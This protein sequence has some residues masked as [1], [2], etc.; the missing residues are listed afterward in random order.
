MTRTAIPTRGFLGYLLLTA[1]I[2]GGLVMVIEVLGSRVIGPFF[3]VSLFVWTSLISVALI[4]LALGYAVGGWIADRRDRPA[5]L[6]TIIALAGLAT[7]LVPL[8][9]GPVLDLTVPLG[10]RAGSFTA[11]LLL[12]GPALWLLGMV[13]PYLVKLARRESATLGFTVGGFYALSTLGSVLGTVLTGFVLIALLGVDRIF[14]LAG[15][16]LLL[17]SAGY[18]VLFARRP[19]AAALLLFALPGWFAGDARVDRVMANGTRVVEVETR[20]SHYGLLQVI[21]YIGGGVHSR[22]L[23]IDGLVQG[24]ID[25]NNGLAVYEY[26]YF[27]QFLPVALHPGGTRALV[28]GLGAGMAPRWYVAR[29]ITVDVVDIDP[30]VVDLARRHL[31]FTTNGR[32]AIEDA[33]TFLARPGPRYDYILLDVFSGDVTPGHLLSREAVTLVAGRLDDGGVLALNLI[34][35]LGEGRFMTASVV[36]TLRTAFDTVEVTPTFDPGIYP[37]EGNLI[38]TAYQ[39]PRRE[40]TPRILSPVHPLA[41]DRVRRNLARRYTFPPG[42]PAIVLTDDYNP[43]DV[44]DAPLR[45]RVRRS[46]IATTEPELLGAG[47]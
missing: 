18:F 29:G 3:G 12:F 27:L 34:G 9:R 25:L 20:D 32:V 41:I 44:F 22:E 42:T 10:L 2:C 17:L 46:I 33:R 7:L 24:G 39:G 37:S 4:A 8:L 36:E 19:A 16:L 40:V 13:S 21:D 11:T 28:I 15:T 35:N 30:D 38:I 6:Y 26:S 5:W 14:Q 43:I 45:E 1:V 31:D 47:G 23:A